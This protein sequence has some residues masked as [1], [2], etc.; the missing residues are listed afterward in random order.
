MDSFSISLSPAAG[1]C[2]FCEDLS[3]RPA[4]SLSL[5]FTS[6]IFCF[7]FQSQSYL[8]ICPMCLFFEVQLGFDPRFGIPLSVV[9]AYFSCVIQY[10]SPSNHPPIV[11]WYFVSSPI[12]IRKMCLFPTNSQLFSYL[13]R[14][15]ETIL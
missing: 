2:I 7:S 14:S 11:L 9:L 3:V 15:S 6:S 5:F 12:T 13:V 8:L 10:S 1:I 4:P